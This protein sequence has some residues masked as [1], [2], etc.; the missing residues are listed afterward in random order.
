VLCIRRGTPCD[1]VGQAYCVATIMIGMASYSVHPE[2]APICYPI[3]EKPEPH[4]DHD[5][6]REPDT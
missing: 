2:G 1:K 3:A 5:S 6:P 4:R